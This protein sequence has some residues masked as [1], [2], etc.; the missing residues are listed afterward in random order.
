MK[1]LL[2]GLTILWFIGMGMFFYNA[3]RIN[4]LAKMHL[5]NRKDLSTKMKSGLKELDST[6]KELKS[7]IKVLKKVMK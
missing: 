6:I 4:K 7:S 2:G 5:D 1:L 3:W